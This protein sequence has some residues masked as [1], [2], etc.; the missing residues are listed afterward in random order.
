M[1]SGA[2]HWITGNPGTVIA[3][4]ALLVTIVTWLIDHRRKRRRITYRIHMNEPIRADSRLTTNTSPELGD[5]VDFV[6]RRKGTTEEVTDPSLVL[7][8]IANKGSLDAGTE[9][10]DLGGPKFTFKDREVKAFKPLEMNPNSLKGALEPEDPGKTGVSFQGS[11]LTL[12]VLN[13]NAGER[14]KLLILLSGTGETIDGGCHMKGGQFEEDKSGDSLSRKTMGYL[15]VSVALVGAL[16][17]FIISGV[18]P[19]ISQN[20]A[21]QC[22]S[23]TISIAGS[24]AFQP[25]IAEIAGLYHRMCP[26]ATITVVGTGSIAGV[27]ALNDGSV[28][29][30]MYD[31]TPT[32]GAYPKLVPH[33]VAVV[34]FAIVVNKQTGVH[35]LTTGQLR[36]IYALKY[37]NWRQ[38][39]GNDLPITIVARDSESG[40]RYTFKN[41]VLGGQQEP[42]SNSQN[43][44]TPDGA[45]D[46]PV[47]VCEMNSTRALLQNVNSIPG[48]IGYA[49]SFQAGSTVFANITYIQIN[50][51]APDL[52]QNQQSAYPF[53]AAEHIYTRGSPANDSLLSAFLAYLTS[54]TAKNAMETNGDVPC[55]NLTRA[56]QMADCGRLPG[57]HACP[58]CATLLPN[59]GD[60]RL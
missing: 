23:G 38:V 45:Q 10:F 1:S 19:S 20:T 11:D 17:A 54:D 28:D 22:V 49:E 24:T 37:S 7:L 60:T 55:G 3:A 50:G 53:W 32:L 35:S 40:T 48:A 12:P 39:G 58:T 6:V 46:S 25:A 29:A 4:A 16:I 5:L 33:P 42:A 44:T 34:E 43:C 13:L 30:A 31:G 2:G 15:A 52:Q 8:R 26:G 14:F 51:L 59:F 57:R 27:N 56:R 47:L 18:G 21:V 36:A 9:H 41:T